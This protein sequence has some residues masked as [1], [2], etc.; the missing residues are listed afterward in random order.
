LGKPGALKSDKA[1]K[2]S[3]ELLHENF[4][5]HQDGESSSNCAGTPNKEPSERKPA[6]GLEPFE[7]WERE[8]ME[9]LL[10]GLRGHLGMNLGPKHFFHLMIHAS[11][12]SDSFP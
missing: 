12:I 5:L 3:V 6:R 2:D 11:C 4:D 7:S 8:E 1:G 9:Q 10:G